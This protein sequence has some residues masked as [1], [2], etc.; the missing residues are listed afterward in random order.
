MVL[1]KQLDIMP[2]GNNLTVVF[3]TRKLEESYVKHIKDTCGIK[4][5][6]ILSYENPNGTSLTEIYN[7]ALAESTNDVIVYC[8]D[9]LIFNTKK[10]GRKIL[11]HFDNTDYGIIGLAGTRKMPE[12]GRWWDDINQPTSNMVG[13][14]KH[15]NEGK[16]WESGYSNSYGHNIIPVV[17]TDGVLFVVHKERIKNNFN[18]DINGF[19]FYD[20]DFTFRNHL[21]GVKIGVITDIRITHLSMGQTNNEWEEN[22][23]LFVERYK[24]NLPSEVPVKIFYN[25]KTPY[26]KKEPKV[27]I[28]IPTKDNLDI[29]FGCLNSIITK[30]KYTNYEILIADTGSEKENLTKIIDYCGEH[31]NIRLIEYD[32][33][34]FA[35]INNEVVRDQVSDDTE[36]LLFCNN[37]IE[38]INDAISGVVH[39]WVKNKKRVGTVGARLHFEDG[40]LQHG[41]VVL[42]GRKSEQ[43]TNIGVTHHAHKSKYKYQI[44]DSARVVGNTGA[45]L[46]VS[47]SLFESCGMFNEEYIDCLEDVELNLSCMVKG[48]EN[49]IN[50]NSICYHYESITRETDGQIRGDDFSRMVNYIKS[51]DKLSQYIQMIK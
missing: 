30:T 24:D 37:D 43:G 32:Y 47:K 21:E 36:L 49:Y 7:K 46:L 28:I 41:G 48:R 39:T 25:D 50:N 8:H 13:I 45:F 6:Q 26:I 12:S 17:I 10:W 27:S 29:L 33:Y 9:D 19:H 2:R 22:R 38:L 3:S 15:S 4:D 14:V 16:T 23:K 18:K 42:F 40:T 34:N 1:T 35:K 20:I 51:N 31:S 5:I 44:G 11:K